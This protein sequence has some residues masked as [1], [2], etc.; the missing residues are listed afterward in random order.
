MASVALKIAHQEIM[1]IGDLT[2]VMILWTQASHWIFRILHNRTLKSFGIVPRF[3]VG[4]KE[5]AFLW[6]SG[7]VTSILEGVSINNAELKTCFP[8]LE[9]RGCLDNEVT[10]V[11]AVRLWGISYLFIYFLKNMDKPSVPVSKLMAML[12]LILTLCT[13]KFI[14]HYHSQLQSFL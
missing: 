1:K 4:A 8:G 7:E 12:P 5:A 10:W 2:T 13:K 6:S 9:W 14:C 11:R 3:T